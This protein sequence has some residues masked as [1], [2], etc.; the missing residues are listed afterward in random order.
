[1][2]SVVG[3]KGF[4]LVFIL[5]FVLIVVGASAFFFFSNRLAVGSLLAFYPVC[6]GNVS[7]V[8]TYPLMET[9]YISAL[10]PFGNLN[11][12]GHTSPVDHNYFLSPLEYVGTEIP[13]YHPADSWIT[14]IASETRLNDTTGKYEPSGYSITYTLCSGVKIEIAGYVR[15]SPELLSALSQAIQK[16]CKEGIV[17][18]NH[19]TSGSC[20]Y[21]M[22]YKVQS[23]Q[24]A[25]WAIG[26]LHQTIEVW[27]Y[28]F[29]RKPRED[30]DWD[31]YNYGNYQYSFCLFDLYSGD[32]RGAYY[33]KF[34][35]TIE[36]SGGKNLNPSAAIKNVSFIP[37]TIEPRCGRI[38]QDVV[39]TI[40]G[41][42]WGEDKK[43]GGDW[44]IEFDGKGLAFVHDNIDPTKGAISIGGN[45]IDNPQEVWFEPTHSGLI[46]REPSEVGADGRIYCY[47]GASDK[48][49][50]PNRILVQL[51]DDHHLKVEAKPG[52]CGASESFSI[53]YTYQR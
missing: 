24:I 53:L 50:T 46:D 38:N 42:W 10:I 30:V 34:G 41:M 28:N 45:F 20:E 12:P 29:N 52:K 4:W 25:G 7:G 27:A 49:W 26:D 47:D 19:P 8:L 15:L 48:S 16:G 51:T 5:L 22:N 32:M 2:F 11:P 31:Y 3:L 6:P 35:G 17:K 1:M 13:I 43:S 37:R 21:E 14:H 36:E 23:G 33:Q 9:K 39:G 40:Q 44:S 18:P